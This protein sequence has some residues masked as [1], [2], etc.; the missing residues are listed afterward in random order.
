MTEALYARFAQNV[1][2]KARE[3]E[4]FAQNARFMSDR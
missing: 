2:L 1:R 4:L 3:K